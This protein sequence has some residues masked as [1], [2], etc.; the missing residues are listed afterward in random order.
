MRHAGRSAP[1]P[2]SRASRHVAR[3]H[4][5]SG[6]HARVAARQNR[7]VAAAASVGG[8]ASIVVD[9]ATAGSFTAMNENAPRH[10]ASVT[11]VMTLYLLFED[12]EKGS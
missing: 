11:K 3:H 1:P 4:G 5:H 7:N 2:S 9:G 12:L 8:T 6:V 10:P